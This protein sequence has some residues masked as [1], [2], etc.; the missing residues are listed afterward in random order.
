MTSMLINYAP[1][2]SIYNLDDVEIQLQDEVIWLFSKHLKGLKASRTRLNIHIL[3][4]PKEIFVDEETSIKSVSIYFDV[5]SFLELEREKKKELLLTLIYDCL[6]IISEKVEGWVQ[7]NIEEAY[8]NCL[9]DECPNV[10][11]TN[12]KQSPNR[13]RKV[14]IKYVLDGKKV[15]LFLLLKIKA[16]QT[17]KEYK[18]IETFLDELAWNK[19]FQNPRWLN[20]GEF[21]FTLKNSNDVMLTYNFEKEFPNW[22]HNG[23]SSVD[24]GHIR[25]VTFREFNSV[26]ER[27][28]WV[29]F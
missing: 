19:T 26:E 3:E 8:Q 18:L 25:R 17:E 15:T 21:G 16:T 4:N 13:K 22:I 5:P 24:L 6:S 10:Y 2:I 29:N 14:A 12:Y 1:F 20:D 23:S 28:R 7:G 9:N 27:R 11:I